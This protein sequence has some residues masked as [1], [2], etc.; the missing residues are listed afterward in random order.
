MIVGHRGRRQDSWSKRRASAVANAVRRRLL[1]DDTP[2]TGCGLKLFPRA[3]FLDLPYFDHMHRFLP[4]L[5]L[6]EGGIVRSVPVNHRPRQRGVSKYG[7]LDRLGVGIVD[8]I[9]RDVAAPSVRRTRTGRGRHGARRSAGA[10]GGAKPA[11]R[12]AGTGAA[13]RFG[14]LARRVVAVG[15]MVAGAAAAWHWRGVFDP[16]AIAALLAGHPFAPLGFIV[17]HVAASLFFVPRTLL[18]VAAGL[19]FGGWWGPVWA[20]LG[21]LAGAVAGYLVARHLYSGFVERADPTRLRA[22]LARA[23]NG[24]W[25]MV[26]MVRLLPLIPHSLTN[27]AFG[28]TRVSLAAYM[29]GSLLGQL[30]LTIA[31]ADL[32]AA[33]GQAML[34]G[35]GWHAGLF[36]PT[37][38]GLGTLGLSLLIPV[39]ARRR[40]RHEEAVAG[41]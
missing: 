21:S 20:A 39:I 29:I 40:M 17:L 14:G 7:V 12:P 36:W 28:L 38:I 22:L 34:G 10:D 25:R 13:M 6:R 18:A 27:Y 5:V 41:S 26:A 23:D 35:A 11:R 3:L 15:L 2:D 32:G 9:R 30:P 37:A 1:R 4:A 31:Y 24:G 16:L 33:G 8:L 19:L